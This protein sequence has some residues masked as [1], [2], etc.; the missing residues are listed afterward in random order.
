M[1]ILK[2]YPEE[3]FLIKYYVIKHLT[4]LKY[5][6]YDKYQHGLASVIYKFFYKKAPLASTSGG[7]VKSKIMS[8][9]KLAEESKNLKNGKYTHLS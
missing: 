7:A 6:K 9:Q 3:Q 5:P 2:I 8:N 1:Q 4:L